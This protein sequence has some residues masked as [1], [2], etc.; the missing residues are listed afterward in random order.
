MYRGAAI[1]DLVGWYLFGDFVSGRILAIPADSVGLVA[2]EEML[3]SAL[4]IV[5][6]G[7]DNDGELYVVDFSLGRIHRLDAAP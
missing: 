4:S 5:A 2:A 3:A 7:E 6:F 1:P